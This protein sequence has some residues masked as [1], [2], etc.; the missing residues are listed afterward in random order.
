MLCRMFFLPK[1]FSSICLRIGEIKIQ[2]QSKNPNKIKK[3]RGRFPIVGLAYSAGNDLDYIPKIDVHAKAYT[4]T[5]KFDIDKKKFK[6]FKRK[7]KSWFQIGVMMKPNII[8]IY[9]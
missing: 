6:I 8:L 3:I 2:F 9:F 5:A 4:Y 1:R 7:F